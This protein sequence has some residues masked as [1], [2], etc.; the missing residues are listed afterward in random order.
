[1]AVTEWGDGAGASTDILGACEVFVA[2][3]PGR[4]LTVVAHPETTTHKTRVSAGHLIIAD[5]WTAQTAASM[6]QSEKKALK[7]NGAKWNCPFP[8]FRQSSF[9]NF[10]PVAQ[11]LEQATHNSQLSVVRNN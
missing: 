6:L 5:Y 11:R 9:G 8:L 1:L 7:M 10:G 2:A 3:G 4:F